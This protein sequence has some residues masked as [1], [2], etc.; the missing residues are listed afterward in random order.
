MTGLP[1]IAVDSSVLVA[2]VREETEAPVLETMLASSEAV[3]GAPTLLESKMVLSE[4]SAREIDAFFDRLRSGGG[5]QLVDFTGE[6]ADAAVSAFRRFG[7]GQGHPAQLNFGDC[8]SYATARVLGVPLL[9][10][11]D[12]F[13][14]TDI[15][16]AWRP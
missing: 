5:L 15:E 1:R 9:F 4:L 7:K 8:L 2:I 12:D 6:M 11:G 16:P 13:A 14:R 10:K 3:I